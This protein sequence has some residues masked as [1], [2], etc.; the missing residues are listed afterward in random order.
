MSSTASS[1]PSAVPCLAALYLA[2]GDDEPAGAR[3]VSRGRRVAAAVTA[4]LVAIGMA[5]WPV[6]PV[7]LAG[8]DRPAAT[9]PEW[10]DLAA[11][12][13]ADLGG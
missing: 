2:L 11:G 12:D 9:L 1:P 8:V 13:A 6:L 3:A 5:A 4:A 7:A 10:P